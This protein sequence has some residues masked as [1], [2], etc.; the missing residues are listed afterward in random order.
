MAGLL[1]DTLQPPRRRGIRF[2]GLQNEAL[3]LFGFGIDSFIEVISGLGIVAMV[4]LAASLIYALT[5]IGFIDS[6]GTLGLNDTN[7]TKRERGHQGST[8]RSF[9]CGHGYSCHSWLLL[10]F[11]V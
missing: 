8:I 7:R 3:T 9:L 4:L 6:L 1:H 5:G 2:F 11:A 10:A